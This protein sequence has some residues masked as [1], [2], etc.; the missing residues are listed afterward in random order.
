MEETSGYGSMS[1]ITDEEEIRV[2]EPLI[3]K[4]PLAKR[5][6]SGIKRVNARELI[7]QTE[8]FIH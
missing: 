7:E 5:H 1:L 6:T 2:P 3:F 8:R 4:L